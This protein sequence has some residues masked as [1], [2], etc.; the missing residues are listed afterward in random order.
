VEKGIAIDVARRE[1]QVLSLLHSFT[2]V[3]AV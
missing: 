3:A 2:L 1:Q